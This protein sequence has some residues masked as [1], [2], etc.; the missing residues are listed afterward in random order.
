[1]NSYLYTKNGKLEIGTYSE[2]GWIPFY[3]LYWHTYKKTFLTSYYL[4]GDPEHFLITDFLGLETNKLLDQDLVVFSKTNLYNYD[5][6]NFYFSNFRFKFTAYDKMKIFLINSYHFFYQI[7]LGFTINLF[8]E[9]DN[10]V[11]L[12]LN[13]NGIYLNMAKKYLK[14]SCSD[15]VLIDFAL[16]FLNG[17]M[18]PEIF[19][20]WV[21]ESDYY[22]KFNR[23]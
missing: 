18:T 5:T 15:S 3:D 2:E 19:Y 8:T 17:K 13:K 21:K 23:W 10:E 12:L 11:N 16:D 7:P 4:E 22:Q 20:D 9:E 14:I 6:Y 1:M